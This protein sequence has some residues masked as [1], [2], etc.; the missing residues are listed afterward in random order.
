[1]RR[2]VLFMSLILVPTSLIVVYGCGDAGK[3]RVEVAKKKILDQIDDALGKMDVQKAEIDTGI[4]SAKQALEGVRR[5][6]IKAQVSAEQL[7]EKVRPFQDK[8]ARCDES[9]AKLR[10]AIKADK[11]ADF[12]GKTYSVAQ[13]NEMA[14]KVIQARKEAAD[15]IK[16]FDAARANMQKV[17]ATITRQQQDLESRLTK[18]QAANSKLDSEMAAAKAMK[19][20]SATMGDANASLSDN[21]DELEKKIAVLSADVRAD[22][23]GESEK[24]SDAKTDKAIS[25]VDAFIQATQRPA[26]TVAEIDRILG[27]AKK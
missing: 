20:A 19:Q 4:K 2:F 18:L 22:L 26:D 12:A 24:W 14:G 1:M 10:D 25:D 17:V 8:I 21:L 7:D 3:A 23:A 27:P 15:Q 13:L 5:A 9:L 11:S 16:G 6:K